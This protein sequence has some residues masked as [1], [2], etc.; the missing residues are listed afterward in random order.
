MFL[1]LNIP[2]NSRSDHGN[3]FTSVP[4][5]LPVERE[6]LELRYSTT[7]LL[8][9]DNIIKVPSSAVSLQITT[10]SPVNFLRKIG[11]EKPIE[12]VIKI[13]TGYRFV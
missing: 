10:T 7:I 3:I 11:V 6:R 12:F 9:E 4:V 8:E 13:F 5:K 2:I 1:S